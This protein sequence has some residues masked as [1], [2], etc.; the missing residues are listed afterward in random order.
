MRNDL[1][2]LAEIIAA[3]F[4]FDDRK[5][6]AAGSPIIRLRKLRVCEALIMAE[7]EVGLG[8]VVGHKDLTVLKR[9]HRTRIDVDVR[10][11]LHHLDLHP[12]RLEQTADARRRKAFAKTRNNTAGY[13]NVFGH[14]FIFTFHVSG[15]SADLRPQTFNLKPIV[16]RLLSLPVSFSGNALLSSV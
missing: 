6:N 1:D 3:A 13:E 12:A 2:R 15:L 11:E 9:R 8:A 10:V 14:M 7:V 4:F 16:L 5:I